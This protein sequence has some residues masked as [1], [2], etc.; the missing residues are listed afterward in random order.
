MGLFCP[1]VHSAPGGIQ[2]VLKGI[3]PL[4]FYKS[5]INFGDVQF[6]KVIHIFKISF[7]PLLFDLKGIFG[8]ARNEVILKKKI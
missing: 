2:S 6:N 1:T 7:R 3:Q 4:P 8:R 5:L